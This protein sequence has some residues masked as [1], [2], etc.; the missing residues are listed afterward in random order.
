VS[1]TPILLIVPVVYAAL[2]FD[3]LSRMQSSWKR[4][5]SAPAY[6]L[7]ACFALQVM[8]GIVSPVFAFHVPV[9]ALVVACLYL[10]GLSILHDRALALSFE[11]DAA[12]DLSGLENVVALSDYR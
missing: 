2:Q 4:A 12:H 6:G 10:A 9:V 1:Y 7:A 11:E 5:A 3:A 8:A